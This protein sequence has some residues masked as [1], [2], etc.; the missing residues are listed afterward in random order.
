MFGRSKPVV[1]D[2]YPRRGSR[3]GL[4]RWLV[5]LLL[6]LAAGAAG[7]IFVQERYLPPR[8]S[9]SE[10]VRLRQAYEQADAD[11]TR[12]QNELAAATRRLQSAVAELETLKKDRADSHALAEELG[13]DLAFA[14]DSLPPDPRDGQVAVRAARLT[15]QRG[16]LNYSVALSHARR[17]GD[18]LGCVMQVVVTGE[19]GGG[20]ER[21]VA[22]QPV[23]LSLDRQA[24]VRG[25]LPLPTGFKPRQATLRV[26]D[27]PGGGQLGMRVI[28]VD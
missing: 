12:L 8:L 13:E 22:L 5:L 3:R 19:S 18:P 17:G 6:G 20:Q 9:A 1:F 26:L 2:P 16:N 25:V 4:P 15:V 14:V 21:S 11:R 7:V 23:K 10:S 27:R 28:L 24:V